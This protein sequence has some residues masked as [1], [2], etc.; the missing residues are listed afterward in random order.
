MFLFDCYAGVKMHHTLSVSACVKLKDKVSDMM[1]S[2]T[3]ID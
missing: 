2:F 1:V 3:I